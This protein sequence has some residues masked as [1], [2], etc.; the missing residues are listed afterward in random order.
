MD[1]RKD[2]WCK[3]CGKRCPLIKCYWLKG[4]GNVSKY[5]PRYSD[6]N[7]KVQVD[8]E[9]KRG[10]YNACKITRLCR[11]RLSLLGEWLNF[12]MKFVHMKS[13]TSSEQS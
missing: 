13:F 11:V 8:V 6:G 10:W 9:Q 4:Y 3:K 12:A 7:P 5:Y 2:V 1:L